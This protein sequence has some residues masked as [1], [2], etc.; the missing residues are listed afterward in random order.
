MSN[1]SAAI[2]GIVIIPIIGGIAFFLFIVW[3]I[4]YE[5]KRSKKMKEEGKEDWMTNKQLFTILLVVFALMAL[6]K[7]IATLLSFFD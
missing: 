4:F 3:A 7:T 2:V 6:P 1:E 5:M